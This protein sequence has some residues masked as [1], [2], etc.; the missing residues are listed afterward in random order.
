MLRRTPENSNSGTAE[1]DSRAPDNDSTTP[2]KHRR[3][4]YR[5]HKQMPARATKGEI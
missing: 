1:R 5:K 4:Q 3:N 2:D